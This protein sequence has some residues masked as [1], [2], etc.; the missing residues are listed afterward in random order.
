MDSSNEDDRK[1]PDADKP[2]RRK[3]QNDQQSETPTKRQRG[4]STE[5]KITLDREAKEVKLTCV[6]ENPNNIFKKETK[7]TITLR[8]DMDIIDKQLQ[9]ISNKIPTGYNSVSFDS[10]RGYISNKKEESYSNGVGNGNVNTNVNSNGEFEKQILEKLDFIVQKLLATEEKVSKLYE[11]KGTIPVVDNKAIEELHKE[12]EAKVFV[13]LD[14]LTERMIVAEERIT[15]IQ[16]KLEDIEKVVSD[17]HK[18][19]ERTVAKN[20]GEMSERSI[21]NKKR[22]NTEY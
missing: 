15:E 12:F 18:D 3:K 5:T 10:S 11:E 6:V 7:F 21:K 13:K 19:L 22:L 14:D 8:E 20:Y 2:P 16:E 9:K 4:K 17:K 1:K